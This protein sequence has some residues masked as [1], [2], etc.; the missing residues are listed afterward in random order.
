MSSGVSKLNENRLVHRKRLTLFCLVGLL[1]CLL[2]VGVESNTFLRHVFQVTPIVLVIG[3]G[4]L[5]RVWFR[6]GALG[7]FACWTFFM[8]LIWLYLAGIQTFFTGNFT[9]FEIV[10]TVVM[11]GLCIIGA[12]VN[13]RPD[14]SVGWPKHFSVSI[15]FTLCQLIVMWLSLFEI[16]FGSL[17]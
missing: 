7:L 8:V 5:K 15:A 14:P 4:L 10:L 6:S 3:I 16:R 11:G 2:A 13:A 17:L 12:V 9:V 1:I